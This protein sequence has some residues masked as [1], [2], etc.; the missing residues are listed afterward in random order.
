MAKFWEL[1]A[2]LGG[3]HS[4]QH[5]LT[6]VARTRLKSYA[7]CPVFELV[8]WHA[9]VEA[10]HIENDYLSPFANFTASLSLVS[11]TDL[12]HLWRGGE[13]IVALEPGD[14]LA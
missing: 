12:R 1:R 4:Q 14:H 7:D 10:F 2:W 3:P 5:F 6:E 13:E 9:S 8:F 11:N